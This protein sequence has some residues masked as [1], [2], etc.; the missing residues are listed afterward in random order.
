MPKTANVI[1]SY[2]PYKACS[3]IDHRT[4]RLTGLMNQLKCDGHSVTLE[5]VSFRDACFITV[6]GEKVFACN[7]TGG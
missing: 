1:I 6:N 2:G 4:N 5:Q 7:L 3:L